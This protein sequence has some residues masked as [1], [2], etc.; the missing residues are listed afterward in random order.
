M[1]EKGILEN[2]AHIIK[3]NTTK[4]VSIKLNYLKVNSELHSF[5]FSDV[6]RFSYSE[7]HSS[8]TIY[9]KNEKKED[10]YIFSIIIPKNIT[11]ILINNY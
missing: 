9:R 1:K 5:S 8:I 6:S 3:N 4:T 7:T 10:V 2:T 11:I